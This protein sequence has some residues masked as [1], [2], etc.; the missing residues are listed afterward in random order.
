MRNVAPSR[1][2]VRRSRQLLQISFLLVTAGIFLAIFGLALY[3]VPL[4]SSGSPSYNA[5]NAGRG[6]LFVGGIVAGVAGLALAIRA[7]TQRTENDLALITGQRLAVQLSDQYTFIRNISKR[8]LGYIDAVLVGPA[9]VLVFRIVDLEGSFLNEAGNW[10]KEGRPGDW[11]AMTFVNPTRD[12]IKDIK[13]LREFLGE[14]DITDV[15]I[16]GV[17]VFT[18]DDPVA[19]LTLKEPAVQATHLSSLYGRLQATYLAK[20]RMDQSMIDAIVDLL[21][22][23]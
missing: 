3:A 23:E 8:G 20:E 19:Q 14:R 21:Y 18:K 12:A 16:F 2:I 4:A 17:V 10:L 5:L 6:V 15:P 7:V 22:E 11:K 13:S 1:V 9:G